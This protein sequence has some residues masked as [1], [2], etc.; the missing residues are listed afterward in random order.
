MNYN[1]FKPN[2]L[3]EMG[4]NDFA[5]E[6]CCSFVHKKKFLAGALLTLWGVSA[7]PAVAAEDTMLQLIINNQL[8]TQTAEQAGPQLINER[9]YVP[10]RL[11]SESLGHRVQWHAEQREIVIVTE[12]DNEPPALGEPVAEDAPITIVIDGQ[13]LVAD[14][15]T[16][17]PFLSGEGYTMIPLRLVGEALHCDVQWHLVLINL[18]CFRSIFGICPFVEGVCGWI[19]KNGYSVMK[20][21]S[22]NVA[23]VT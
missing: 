21:T 16:G 1:Y 3:F 15:N 5:E 20:V 6:G 8:Y 22:L 7:L 9:V 19:M 12:G 14:E 18:H 4:R 11:V 13:R 17:Q 23:V 2:V 10:L